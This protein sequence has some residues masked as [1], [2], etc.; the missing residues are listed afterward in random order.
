MTSGLRIL[1][2][3]DSIPG[4]GISICHSVTIKKRKKNLLTF[5]YQPPI[6][7]SNL[8]SIFCH[9]KFPCLNILYDWYHIIY[10]L[11]G[12]ASYTQH[13]FRIHPSCSIYF[14]SFYGILPIHMLVDGHFCCF[15]PLAI[16]D[17]AAV[18]ICVHIFA[19]I[20]FHLSWVNILE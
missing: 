20:C 19:S 8:K 17:N 11:L 16:M 4:Q 5:N 6:D 13:I 9:C 3:L 2:L 18:T 1:V 15:H 14:I 12:L 10:G 7:L